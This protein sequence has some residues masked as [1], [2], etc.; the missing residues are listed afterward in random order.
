MITGKSCSAWLLEFPEFKMFCF[1]NVEK[2][3]PVIAA[4]AVLV[5]SV[6]LTFA[7]IPLSQSG[8]EQLLKETVLES[9][10]KKIRL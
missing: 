8:G 4:T 5:I 3:G 9:G 7:Q 10:G 2:Y 6:P 1:S